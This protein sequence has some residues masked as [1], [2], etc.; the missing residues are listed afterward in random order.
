MVIKRL[1]DTRLGFNSVVLEEVLQRV[2]S[3]YA[4]GVKK[5]ILGSSISQSRKTQEV[6]VTLR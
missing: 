4:L 2:L 6:R 5:I 3:K 1:L